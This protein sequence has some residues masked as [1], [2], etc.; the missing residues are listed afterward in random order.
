M[1]KLGLLIGLFTVGMNYAQIKFE[2]GYIINNSGEKTEVL[3]KDLDWKNNPTEFEYKLNDVSPV[4]KEDI[5]N[6]S[7][8]AVNNSEKYVRKTVMIDHS[9]DIIAYISKNKTPDFKEETLFLKYVVEGKANLF[10]YQNTDTK[11]FFYN[12]DQSDVKQLVYKPYYVSEILVRYNNEY[13][14]QISENLTCGI[15]NKEIENADYKTNALTKIFVKYNACS[16]GG[17]VNYAEIKEKRDFFNLNIR[18]GISSSK[19]QTTFN[20]YD[21][22]GKA[23]FDR[24]FTFRIGAEFEFLLPYNKNKWA[25]FIEPTY[26]YYKTDS[27]TT[28]NRGTYFER[29]IT[30]SIDYKSLDTPIGIRHYMFLNDKSKIFVNA[31]FILGIGL[32]S[33]FKQ[34][35]VEMDIK[36]ANN[37]AFGAGYKYD[38]KFSVELRVNTSRNLL[39]N[40]VMWDSDYSTMSLIFGY[41]LF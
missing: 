39:R 1:K 12:I 10:Y 28:V 36:T 20:S 34:D 26:Q 21:P 31:A 2:K 33:S 9:S 8:F 14:K 15:E 23:D 32:N 29:K 40:Y 18:P 13:K 41:T 7:E 25:I 19:F 30:Q 17:S 27:E 22:A 6:I 37:I 38:D 16:N 35:N 11:R 3:I 5:K 24:K 4:K